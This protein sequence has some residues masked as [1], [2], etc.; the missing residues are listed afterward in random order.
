MTKFFMSMRCIIIDDEKHC[1]AVVKRYIERLP[2]MALVGTATNPFVGIEL[3]EKERPD[4]VFLDIEMDE[5]N[6]IELSKRISENTCIVF[7]SAYSEAVVRRYGMNAVDYLMKPIEFNRFLK[8]V[9][10][11][12]DVIKYRNT[13]NL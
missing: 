11:V 13:G 2:D 10:R 5:M 1:I 9:Q 6:G 7:C 8:A 12:S 4:V 3:I